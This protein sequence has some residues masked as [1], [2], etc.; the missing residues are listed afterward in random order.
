M[1]TKNA[2]TA[3]LWPV[4]SIRSINYLGFILLLFIAI[5]IG[6]CKKDLLVSNPSKRWND[7]KVKIESITYTQFLNLIDLKKTGTLKEA[8]SIAPSKGIQQ[9]TMSLEG[10]TPQFEIDMGNVKKLVV[11]G[12]T[13]YVISLK[14]R[15]RRAIQF[16]NITIQVGGDETTAFLTT[17]VPTKEWIKEWRNGAHIDTLFRGQIYANKISLTDLPKIDGVNSS[18]SQNGKTMSRNESVGSGT[19]LVNGHRISLVEVKCT[20]YDVYEVVKMPCKFGHYSRAD[21]NFQKKYGSWEPQE[22]DWPPYDGYRY[23]GKAENCT[24]TNLPDPSGGGGGGNGGGSTTPNPPGD[25]DPCNGGPVAVA[26]SSG[27]DFKSLKIALVPPP[28]DCDDDN[29]GLTPIPTNSTAL[30]IQELIN[31]LPVTDP[32]QQNYLATNATVTV[33][34][35]DYLNANGWTQDNKEF[36][37]W[38]IGYLMGNTNSETGKLLAFRQAV[39]SN[40]FAF[41]IDVDCETLKKWLAIAKFKPDETI[42]A[43][44]GSLAA[45]ATNRGFYIKKLAYI[46]KIDDAYSAVVNMDY[47]PVKVDQLPIVNG[48]RLGPGQFL[49]YIRTHINDFTDGSKTFVPYNQYG[50][51]DTDKW[52]STTPKGSIIA[53]DLAGPENGSVITS[54]S[55]TDMWTF[56]TIHEPM[57]GDHPVSG[58]RNFGYT[59][60]NDGSYTFYTRGVDRLT[61]WDGSKLQEFTN[62]PFNKAD[63][64]WKS[65]QNAIS[66]FVN[67]HNGVAT[68]NKAETFRPDWQNVK[69]VLEGKKPLSSLSKNCD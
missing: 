52:N 48:Q 21:C 60:N 9:R 68:T 32:S 31:Y 19:M 53:I 50:I 33:A 37:K 55:S 25:Y 30:A 4:G 29:G 63:E 28:S 62:I 67:S 64:L 51:N 44:L 58:N 5:G 1:K 26:N 15:T 27:G 38:A 47:F 66:N 65:F 16:Q 61:S 18:L 22:G 23:V 54:Y 12:R 2:L 42:I 35:R 13:S 17:Y 46:Q 3:K 49:N 34:L 7:D 59:L 56:T 36:S 6:S 43:D 14:P 24:I 11:D 10:G 41:F 20:E 39:K 45:A 40:P 8:L 69:D 57:Y